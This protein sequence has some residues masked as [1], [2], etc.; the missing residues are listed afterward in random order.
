MGSVW[1]VWDGREETIWVCCSSATKTK[2]RERQ[3]LETSTI[4]VRLATG[5]HLIFFVENGYGAKIYDICVG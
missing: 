4:T 3:C 1:M 2:E 5:S